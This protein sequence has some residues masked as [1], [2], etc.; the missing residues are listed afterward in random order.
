MEEVGVDRYFH[1]PSDYRAFL[2]LG[3]VIRE[4]V[5]GSATAPVADS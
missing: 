4:V 3:A 1:K 5:H 2:Q